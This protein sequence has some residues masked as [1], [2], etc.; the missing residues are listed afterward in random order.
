LADPA[1]RFALI[2]VLTGTKDRTEPVR[3]NLATGAL[4]RLPVSYP[5]ISPFGVFAW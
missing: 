1:G 3:I 4:T 2:P 5:E